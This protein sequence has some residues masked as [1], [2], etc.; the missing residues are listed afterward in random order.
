MKARGFLG[1]AARAMPPPT[2][3]VTIWTAAGTFTG[4]IVTW[5]VTDELVTL[6]QPDSPPIII[7]L[8]S[9]IAYQVQPAGDG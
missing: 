8:P 9:I 7:D 5:D 3:P 6:D 4:T 1:G 2:D